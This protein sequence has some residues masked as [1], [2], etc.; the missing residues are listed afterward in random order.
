MHVVMSGNFLLLKTPAGSQKNTAGVNTSGLK[1]NSAAGEN[2]AAV[3][4]ASSKRCFYLWP[5]DFFN[6]TKTKTAGGRPGFNHM[7]LCHGGQCHG[8]DV[9]Q[10]WRW[11]VTVP[12]G[13][14]VAIR[15]GQFHGGKHDLNSA[16]HA[17]TSSSIQ[18]P[19]STFCGSTTTTTLCQ[20]LSVDRR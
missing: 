19:S 17:P 20:S 12:A 9:C 3:E 11:A 7:P 8:V 10:R 14:A 13:T 1:L 2:T 5:V 4:P 15:G 18:I 16:I 6:S